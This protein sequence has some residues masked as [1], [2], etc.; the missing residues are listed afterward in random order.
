MLTLFISSFVLG[1]VFNAAPGAVFAETIRH[2]VKGGYAGALAVQLGSLVGDATWA[3]L[4][5]VGV[6]LLLQTEALRLPIGICGVLYL[7]WLAQDSWKAAKLAQSE[8]VD[9]TDAQSGAFRAGV[10]LSVTNPQN[11]AY[12]AAV[13]SA[14][15]A[16]G[17][18]HPENSHYAVYFSGFMTASVVWAF[19]CAYLVDSVFK[20]ASSSWTQA[21]YRMCAIAF[22]VLALSSA[23]SL[24]TESSEKTRPTVQL[25]L[26]QNT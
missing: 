23:R 17:I 12:W 6:G 22:L 4:G 15:S 2:G 5:L 3:I 7:L 20:R 1:L 26:D 25:Q 19:V 24:V 8:T 13:G 14:M 18:S 21:T 9:R 10:L 11:L 16:L